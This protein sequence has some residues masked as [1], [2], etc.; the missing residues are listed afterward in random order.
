MD[1]QRLA[2]HL[3][4][5]VQL[6]TGPVDV[7]QVAIGRGH[8]LAAAHL[9]VDCQR[10]ALHLF[11]TV[12]LTTGP[13]N[14]AQVAVLVGHALAAAQLLMD[15]KGPV[16][17]LLGTVQ[18]TTGPIDDTQVAQTLRLPLLVSKSTFHRFLVGLFGLIQPPQTPQEMPK[19]IRG[20]RATHLHCL[21][22]DLFGFCELP[23][24]GQSFCGVEQS[25]DDRP[26]NPEIKGRGLF[27]DFCGKQRLGFDFFGF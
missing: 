26:L 9:L 12:Q 13:V 18:L 5:T 10:L 3:L 23:L 15:R 1:C 4:G 20:I 14:D 27:A 21:G 7:A 22:E 11:G 2:V 24:V 6:T 8:A 19:P 17:H 16:V 25:E